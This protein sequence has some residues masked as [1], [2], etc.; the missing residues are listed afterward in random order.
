MFGEAAMLRLDRPRA[1]VDGTVARRRPQPA[2]W[3]ARMHESRRCTTS[4]APPG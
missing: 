3:Y 2:R 1:P 4:W